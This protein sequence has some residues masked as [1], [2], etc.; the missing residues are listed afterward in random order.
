MQVETDYL[1]TL[2]DTN[3][4]GAEFNIIGVDYATRRNFSNDE[5][6]G[7]IVNDSLAKRDLIIEELY[8]IVLNCTPIESAAKVTEIVRNY[9]DTKN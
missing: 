5:E 1:E 6:R 8:N 9:N 3:F 7:E 2:P 4:N